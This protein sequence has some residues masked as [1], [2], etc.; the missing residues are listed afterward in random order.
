MD[1]SFFVLSC[2]KIIIYV[3]KRPPCERGLS[4]QVTGGFNRTNCHLVI[5]SERSDE[6]SSI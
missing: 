2:V 3:L 4:P 5:P 6:E 1:I